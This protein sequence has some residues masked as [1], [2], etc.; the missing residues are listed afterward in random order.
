VHDLSGSVKEWQNFCGSTQGDQAKICSVIGGDYKA[1]SVEQQLLSCVDG[2]QLRG[3][4][5]VGATVGFRC[6]ADTTAP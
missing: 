5:D 1:Y 3:V 4:R 2:Y 6:C